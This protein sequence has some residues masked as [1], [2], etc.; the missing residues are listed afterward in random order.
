[1]PE[2]RH[3]VVDMAINGSGIRDTTRV[4]RLS[5]TTVIAILKKAAGQQHANHALLLPPCSRA[6][7]VP[8]GRAIE[9]HEMWSFVGAK[10]RARWL[11][12]AIDHH[13]GRVLAYVI[14]SRKDAMFLKLRTLLAPF[15]ITR[16]YTDKACV[17]Q[18]HLPSSTRWGS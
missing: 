11:W 18:R 16:Y 9:L 4:L 2:V 10:E 8:A 13:T 17:Y 6:A 3:Q 12:H 1:M 15:G 7:R 14:G 5:P